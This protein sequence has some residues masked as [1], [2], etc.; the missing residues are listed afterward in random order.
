M[1]SKKTEGA[2]ATAGGLLDLAVQKPH[3][4]AVLSLNLL[5]AHAGR[6]EVVWRGERISRIP[7]SP[8]WYGSWYR[9]TEAFPGSSFSRSPDRRAPGSILDRFQIF[10]SS[11]VKEPDELDRREGDDVDDRGGDPADRPLLVVDGMVSVEWVRID[12]FSGEEGRQS[13]RKRS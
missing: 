10:G 4:A 7:A 13:G 9:W 1:T 8:S 11:N 3:H 6:Q 12:L 5:L 2:G